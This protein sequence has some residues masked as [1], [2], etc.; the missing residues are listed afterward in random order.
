MGITLEQ[1]TS[2]IGKVKQY[3]DRKVN[4]ISYAQKTVNTDLDYCLRLY[5]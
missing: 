2:S 4:Q 1:L 3:T 5:V